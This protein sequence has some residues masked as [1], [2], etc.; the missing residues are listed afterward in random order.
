VQEL[1]KNNLLVTKKGRKT[2]R[3]RI[4]NVLTRVYAIDMLLM[5]DK[6]N[7]A[8]KEIEIPF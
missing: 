4:N 1:Y 8:S 7:K 2:T 3:K 5:E 6:I